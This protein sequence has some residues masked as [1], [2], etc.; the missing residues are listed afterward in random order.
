MLD[1]A[2]TVLVDVRNHYEI[3]VGGFGGA[4]DP[5]TENFR[6]FP[7]FA[8]AH[9]AAH[10]D[11]KIA[12]YCTGGVR[13]EKASAYLKGRGFAR[14]YQLR[15][16]VLGYLEA[17]PAADSRWRGACFVFDDRVAVDR[18]LQPGD[19]AQCHACRAPVSR[20]DMRDER[21]IP[22]VACRYCYAQKS[23]ADRARFSQRQ[24]QVA[25]AEARDEVHIG[26]AAM[27]DD[28]VAVSV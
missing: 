14:V 2:E 5:G 18:R 11:K 1:D 25:L 22:G 24:K 13:C 28:S 10:K 19:Y 23:A 7:A 12:M 16:G 17:V 4:V 6:E 21:Y 26:P 3:R 15:G 9:L 20:A 8:E 27:R